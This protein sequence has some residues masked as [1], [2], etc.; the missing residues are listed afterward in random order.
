MEKTCLRIK[1]NKVCC[2]KIW[3]S[4][5]DPFGEKKKMFYTSYGT[6]IDNVALLCKFCGCKIQSYYTEME[7]QFIRQHYFVNSVNVRYRII[8]NTAKAQIIVLFLRLQ[9]NIETYIRKLKCQLQTY[10]LDG[11][12]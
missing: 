8:M 7:L 4:Y 6:T 9:H 11:K 12:P 2:M 5:F 10:G 1:L 3:E